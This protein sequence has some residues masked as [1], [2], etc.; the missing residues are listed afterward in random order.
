MCLFNS[1][2]V[3]FGLGSRKCI[4]E[5]LARTRLFLTLCALMQNFTFEADEAYPPPS[6]DARNYKLK[7]IFDIDAYKLKAVCR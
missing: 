5:Q 2:L 1:A 7:I 6:D 4:G 3:N